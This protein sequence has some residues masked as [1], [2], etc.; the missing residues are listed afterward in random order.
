MS[1]NHWPCVGGFLK[2][3]VRPGEAAAIHVLYV[4]AFFLSNTPP[5]LNVAK[6][7]NEAVTPSLKFFKNDR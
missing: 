6:G 5:N 3:D 2:S 1:E 7:S 4:P